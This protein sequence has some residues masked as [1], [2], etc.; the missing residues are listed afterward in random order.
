MKVCY[1]GSY[2]QGESR[3]AI[4]I[5]GLRHLGV[6][7]YECRTPLWGDTAARL[8]LASGSR[9]AAGLLPRLGRA[10]AELVARHLR[11]PTYDV[12][13]VGYPGHLHMPLARFLAWSRR[14]PLIFDPFISLTETIVED[15]A[16]LPG[17]SLRARLLAA[18]DRLTLC[19]AD[20]VLADTGSHAGHFIHLGAR[21]DTLRQVNVGAP[22]IYTK[23]QPPPSPAYWQALYYGQF[24]PLHGVDVMVAAAR[25]LQ[26]EPR[27]RLRLVGQG[28]CWAATTSD[29]PPNLELYPTWLP[30]ADLLQQH[31]GP[32]HACLGIFGTT[33]KAYRVIPYKVY[34]ALAAGKPVL[35]GDTPAARE[36]L[37]P[38]EAAYLV[39]PGDP[40]ALAEA[41][42]HLAANPALSARLAANGQALYYQR[43]SPA[44]VG[45]DV[46]RIILEITNKYKARI[47]QPQPMGF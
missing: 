44:A 31:I 21:P 46:Y 18:L 41:L 47:S 6:Q 4:I 5:T 19:L 23:P 7:V 14:K 15:R 42:R 3:N 9:Q 32:A 22:W 30:A 10:W 45:L 28:Q 1:F 36:L 27:L 12:M 29:P 39:P 24:I 33:P 11:V 26:S 38:Y 43:F 37:Q 25:L 34:A 20:G 13:I 16:L 35:T 2:D 40:Q 17:D 8:E